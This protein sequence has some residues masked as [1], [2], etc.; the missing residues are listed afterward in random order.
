[1]HA[2]VLEIEGHPAAVYQDATL[3][4]LLVQVGV[5]W[6]NDIDTFL[7]VSELLNLGLL[8]VIEDASQL[9]LLE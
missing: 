6:G 7:T 8:G 3:L 1:M 5:E 2:E 4:T 9:D